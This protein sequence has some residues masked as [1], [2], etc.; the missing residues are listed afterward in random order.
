VVSFVPKT[1]N[2]AFLFGA[3]RD[4]IAAGQQGSSFPHHGK[5]SW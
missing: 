1:A 2:T 5:V 4:N 3:Q